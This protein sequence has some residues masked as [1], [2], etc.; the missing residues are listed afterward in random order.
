MRSKA[1]A[2]ICLYLAGGT[3]LLHNCTISDNED[4][5]FGGGGLKNLALLTLTCCTVNANF[6]STGAGI[7]NLNVLV[8]TN[9]TVSGNTCSTIKGG[10]ILN[11]AADWD[12]TQFTNTLLQVTA[13]TIASNNAAGPTG[14]GGIDNN[15]GEVQ[16]RATILADNAAMDFS[17]LL[18]SLGYNL[19][20]NTNGIGLIGDFTGNI[21]GEDPLIGP[22]R[23]N[24]GHTFTQAL[25]TGSPA[26][27]A[28]PTNG[29]PHFDQR[30]IPRPEGSA[31]DI[32]AFELVNRNSHYLSLVSAGNGMQ[33]GL[34]G[35]SGW[36]Y[37]IQRASSLNGPWT[38]LTNMSVGVGG[39]STCM[40]SCSPA[41]SAFYRLVLPQDE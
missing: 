7:E 34:S 23:N 35:L 31:E 36:N 24:G 15:G 5:G 37:I 10:A 29:L 4:F 30:G 26:I 8:M 3:N 6:S 11:T 25:L 21:Y 13:C 18:N 39:K 32:G 27:N 9:C 28:G 12:G 41:G 2:C 19:I 38:T 1:A 16:L 14:I 17:G 33:I 40:D 22:L 20:L